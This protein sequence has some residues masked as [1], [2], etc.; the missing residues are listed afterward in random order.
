M[1]SERQ[2]EELL[3][4][5]EGRMQGVIQAYLE[6][7][8]EHLRAIGQLTASDVHRLTEMKRVGVNASR[9]QK[10]LAK[11]A[12]LSISEL[13]GVFRAVAES[14]ARFAGQ[15]FAAGYPPVVKG[16]P[17]LS[18]PIERILKAQLRVTG[19]AFQNLS[20]TTILTES[21]R[22]AVDVAVQTVQAGL[23]DYNSAIRGAM[24]KAA[25][26]GLRVQYPNSGLTRR[27]DTA[28]R[29]NVLDGV[30]SLNQDVL[31]QLGKEYGADGVELSAHALCAEDHLPYQGRQFSNREFA[32]IQN[33]LDRPFGMW[34]CKH[35]IYPILLGI[36]PPAYTEKELESFRRNS[37]EKISIDGRTMSR[38]QWTQEQRRIE[39]AVRQQKGIAV[40]A[41]ASGDMTARRE[42]QAV[43]G[44][45]TGRYDAISQAAGL[46]EQKD[47]MTVSGFRPVKTELKNASKSGIIQVA[48]QT[49]NVKMRV[50]KQ[51]EHVWN[52]AAF[53]KRTD[54]AKAKNGSL[55]SAFYENVDIEKLVKEHMGKGTAK[56]DLSGAVSEYFSAGKNIG[57]TY[58]CGSGAYEATSRVCIK[59]SKNGWHAFPVKEVK[60]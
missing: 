20:Q 34:N 8:G 45:L 35:T 59:Y 15:W 13:D 38:Y 19:Q 22:A 43:I 11:A 28:V 1:L 47:R 4:Q 41:K 46:I 30:R 36:S 23:A 37:S 31:N 14:D 49:V 10:E 57:W 21:Y 2:L 40:M 26:D 42:A 24:K 27:L 54:A 53:F 6:A 48:G 29:Q 7:M 3:A 33:N 32:R 12:N 52:S 25:A 60:E 58:L 55:P 5:F 51:Q 44:K 18:T 56:K 50:Q 39:T 17:K 16:A 9:I